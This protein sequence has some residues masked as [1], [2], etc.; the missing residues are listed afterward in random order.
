MHGSRLCSAI[1]VGLCLIAHGGAQQAKPP[2]VK[3]SGTLRVQYSDRAGVA[4]TDGFEVR[5]ARLA[6]DWKHEDRLQGRIS[7]ELASGATAQASQL[8]DAFV[9]WRASD[10]LRLHFGQ[11][12]LPL[13]YDVRTSITQLD[14]PERPNFVNT[15]YAGGRGRGGYLDYLFARA[16]SLRWGLWNSLTNN[17]PQATTRASQARLMTTLHLQYDTRAYQFVL[18]GLWGRRPG[19]ATRDS[20]NNPLT[21]AETDRWAWYLEGETNQ[22]GVPDLKLRFTYLRGRDRN[23]AGGVDAPRFVNPSDFQVV[24]L[25]A[26]YKLTTDQQVVLRWEDFDPDR[27]RQGDTQRTLG[28]FYHRYPREYLRLTLGYEWAETTPRNRAICAVQYQF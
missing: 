5:L 22:W 13:F 11:M 4:G 14:A 26:I 27:D 21:V 10:R 25:Y 7:V 8:L 24:D 28:L 6:A 17:D 1:G 20:N 12:R 16:W 2:S 3:I 19:L 23:P 15:Y 9:V 18:G